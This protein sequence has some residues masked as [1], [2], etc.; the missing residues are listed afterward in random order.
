MRRSINLG[1]ALRGKQNSRTLVG[2]G[3]SAVHASTRGFSRPQ[4]EY[5]NSGIAFSSSLVALK[6]AWSG[7]QG[8]CFAAAGAVAAPVVVLE[9]PVPPGLAGMFDAPV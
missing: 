1:Y 2:S 7:H 8:F 6:M 3:Y 5:L 9:P 4:V